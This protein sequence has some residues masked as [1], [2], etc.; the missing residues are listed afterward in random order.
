[1]ET[2]LEGKVIDFPHSD[3][4]QYGKPITT[5]KLKVDKTKLDGRIMPDVVDIIIQEKVRIN[6]GETVRGVYNDAS[7][8]IFFSRYETL[9]K[10][11]D[12]KYRNTVE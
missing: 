10:E 1:M 4:T 9:D 11:G 12:I 5:F 6:K 8:S 2:Q 7:T 3:F